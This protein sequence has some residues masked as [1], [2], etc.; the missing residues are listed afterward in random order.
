MLVGSGD[1][2][3]REDSDAASE[4]SL[5]EEVEID[6]TN[7]IDNEE[8]DYAVPDILQDSF[9]ISDLLDD[10]LTEEI[11]T[12][13]IIVTKNARPQPTKD[14][15]KK[16]KHNRSPISVTSRKRSDNP[17]STS[18]SNSSV[19]KDKNGTTSKETTK[20]SKASK[21]SVKVSKSTT[22]ARKT[23]GDIKVK[24]ISIKHRKEGQ[25]T[26]VTMKLTKRV[27]KK[28]RKKLASHSSPA[29]VESVLIT[30]TDSHS[31][32]RKSASDTKLIRKRIVSTDSNTKITVRK[33]K[34]PK[35]EESG[36]SGRRKAGTTDIVEVAT[37]DEPATR[38][39]A[40][41]RISPDVDV[42]DEPSPPGEW[43][44]ICKISKYKKL[45]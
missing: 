4:V 3:E 2:Y 34:R 41:S 18:N 5:L 38:I 29:V 6:R 27:D 44:L 31:V 33:T 20:A 14:R 45:H 32:K 15:L 39:Y 8:E 19:N 22:K 17:S 30:D 35:A 37:V 12:A 9:D 25:D 16:G 1:S 28:D 40:A 36:K 11:T 23:S 10:D 21:S 42:D 43:P 26:V 7:D 13:P 24:G